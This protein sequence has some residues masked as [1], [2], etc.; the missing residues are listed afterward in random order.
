M[1]LLV[2]LSPPHSVRRQQLLP[3][4]ARNYIP[5][6]DTCF[7]GR[8]AHKFDIPCSDHRHRQNTA[9]SALASE[10]SHVLEMDIYLRAELVRC[11][12]LLRFLTSS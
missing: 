5:L 9:S 1:V 4:S 8:P 12:R 10:L 3:P 2:V 7:P 6:I 11:D